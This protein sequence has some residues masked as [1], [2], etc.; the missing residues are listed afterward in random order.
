MASAHY[1]QSNG[2]AKAAVKTAKR[3]LSHNKERG[4]HIDNEGFALSLLM[5]RNTPVYGV[6]YSPTQMLFGRPLKDALL[7][8]PG[9]FG[10]DSRTCVYEKKLLGPYFGWT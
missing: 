10:W 4:G 1:P 6:G 9:G 5:Y 8:P 2:R 3:V 7:S